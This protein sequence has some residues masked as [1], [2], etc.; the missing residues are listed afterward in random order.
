MSL[1]LDVDD[2][3]TR[4]RLKATADELVQE[5]LFALQCLGQRSTAASSS[6]T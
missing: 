3:S 2:E 1:G 6:P 5:R 4:K